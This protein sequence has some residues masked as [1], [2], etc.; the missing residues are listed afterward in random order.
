MEV[1]LWNNK[2]FCTGDKSV[3]FRNLTEKGILQVGDLISNKNELIIKSELRVLHLLP[4]DVFRLVYLI[5]ALP[6]QWRESLKTCIST[7]DTPINLRDEIKLSLSR[8]IV[9]LEKA[10]SKIVYKEL[11]NRLVTPPTA[12]LKFNAHFVDDTL[13]WKKIYSLHIVLPWIQRLA[14]FSVSLLTIPSY[15]KLV[16]YHLQRAH[17]V[18]NRMNPSNIFSCL[19]IILRIS[20]L[21]L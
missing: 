9:L 19:V 4:L 18:V 16:L 13:N 8:Q 5:D 14:N 7:G 3:Y 1:I 11:R 20:G 12:K 6:T 21:R 10:Y 15:V 2:F 17:Y